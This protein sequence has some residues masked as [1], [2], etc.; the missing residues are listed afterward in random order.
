MTDFITGLEQMMAANGI[1]IDGKINSSSMRWQ[2]FRGANYAT[3]G[4]DLFVKIQG[5]CDGA[6]FGDWHDQS[7]WQTWWFRSWKDL[8]PAERRERDE[9]KREMEQQELQE[10]FHA[11]RNA[12][13]QW[14]NAGEVNLQ[15][16]YL[17]KKCIA[18]APYIKQ[19]ENKL[20]LPLHDEEGVLQSIQYITER[21]F[22]FYEPGTSFKENFIYLGEKISEEY[23][24]AIRICEGWATGATI[25]DVMGDVVVCATSASNIPVVASIFR[26]KHRKSM[27]KIC[28]DN[29]SVGQQY[30]IDATFMTG[31]TLYCPDFKSMDTTTNPS[32]F[33]DLFCLAGTEEVRKQLIKIRK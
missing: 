2:R 9:L 11:R 20:A 19:I 31:S 3:K 6:T 26:N 33:N 1:H 25:H 13:Q 32:D 8:T 15:H 10:R 28:A 14:A 22:K 23:E 29:D 16:P 7:T 17:V 5:N 4:K 12:E 27:L 30:A 21:G 18:K 24:G